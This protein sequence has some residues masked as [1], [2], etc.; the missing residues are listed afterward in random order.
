MEANPNHPATKAAHDHW[1]KIAALLMA[2]MGTN[3]VIIS[4]EEIM[5]L[6]GKNIT[7]R[8]DDTKGI[9]LRLLSEAESMAL[10]RKE[11]GLSA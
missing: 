6:E 3:H 11:G 10:L 8:F 2:K 5:G 9:E 7:V 4:P 1:H